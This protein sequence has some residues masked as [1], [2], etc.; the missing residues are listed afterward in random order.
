MYLVGKVKGTNSIETYFRRTRGVEKVRT[1]LKKSKGRKM[2]HSYTR[3]NYEKVPDE[4]LINCFTDT[5]DWSNGKRDDF[6]YQ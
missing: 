4:F 5:H 6:F 1:K 3:D 2:D